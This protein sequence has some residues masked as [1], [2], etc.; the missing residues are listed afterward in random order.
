MIKCL[1]CQKN[2]EYQI[3]LQFIFS[4]QSLRKHSL[5][6]RCQKEFKK[7]NREKSCSGCGRELS[8][9]RLCLDCQ[10]WQQKYKHNFT[11][12]SIYKYNDAMQSFMRQYKFYG[13]YR[14]RRMFQS[15]IKA[16]LTDFTGLIIPIPVSDITKK[17]RGF[18]QVLGLL[19][20]LSVCDALKV[21]N[22]KK[23][24]QSLKNRHDRIST[25]QIFRMKTS[26][27]EQIAHRDIIII[28]DIYTTGTTIHHAAKIIEAY[29]PSSVRG[30]TLCHG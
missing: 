6:L 5:C 9:S 23:S 14:L 16:E 8:K 15:D 30:L 20:G 21:K 10:K 1:W 24:Q 3:S 12:V 22:V 2:I 29:N 18:N 7:I 25:K 13:D 26:F 17:Q 19:E 28:D 4:C 27:I 11:N